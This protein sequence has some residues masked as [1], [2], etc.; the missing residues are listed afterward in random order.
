MFDGQ[1]FFGVVNGAVPVVVVANR[2]VENVI[3]Q[4]PIKGL[5]LRCSG[6]F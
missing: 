1:Q 3:A 4:N 5:S 6:L 2:A